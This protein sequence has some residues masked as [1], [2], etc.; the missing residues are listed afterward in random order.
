MGAGGKIPADLRLALRVLLK[1][2]LFAISAV[3]TLALGIGAT[4]AIFSAM[5]A[6]LLRRIPVPDPQGIVYLMVPDGQPY[7]ASNTGDSDS[8]FSLPVFE[9]LRRD[10][11]VFS[12]LMAF[13]PLSTDKVDIRVGKDLPEQASGEMVSGN[14]FSGLGVSV[15]VG[16]ALTL[17]DENQHAPVAV[18]S[19]AFWTR[20]FSRDASV[21]G[22][23]LYIKGIPFTIVGIAAQGF[24]GVEPGDITDFW[25]PLQR[26]NETPAQEKLVRSRIPWALH[27]NVGER[28]QKM[29]RCLGEKQYSHTRG[30]QQGQI[31]STS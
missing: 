7:G 14:F 11:R 24:P 28:F 21:L 5:N 16:R 19:Y 15:V 2:P 12:D 31:A 3:I 6:V 10:H 26:R 20:R 23:T 1:S 4:T 29:A 30:A 17:D 9:S 18:L 22:K 13:V 25:I 8:S 27:S